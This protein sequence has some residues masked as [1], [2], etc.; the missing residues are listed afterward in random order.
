MVMEGILMNHNLNTTMCATVLEVQ[1]GSLL[2]C[3]CCTHQQVQV[4]TDQ[5]CCFSVG[6]YLCI[7]YNGAMTMSIP[8]QISAQ[9]ISRISC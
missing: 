6:D 1:Q 8:P 5:A 3:D 7:H 2:V 9:C 4:N